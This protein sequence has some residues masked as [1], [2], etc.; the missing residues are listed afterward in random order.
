LATERVECRLAVI[1]A[2]D[3]AGYSRLVRETRKEL[4]HQGAVGRRGASL[5]IAEPSG[6]RPPCRRSPL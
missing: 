1:L 5:C 3:A 6:S 2:A 4:S